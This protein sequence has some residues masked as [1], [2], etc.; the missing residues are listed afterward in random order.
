VEVRLLLAG[1]T[2]LQYRDIYRHDLRTRG[3]HVL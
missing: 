3:P 2:V 1:C